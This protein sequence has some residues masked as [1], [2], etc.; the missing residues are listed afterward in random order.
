MTDEFQI[1]AEWTASESACAEEKTTA[2]SLCIQFRDCIATFV[3]DYRSK[4]NR[5]YI[6]TS[7]YPLALWFASSWW[8]LRWEPDTGRPATFSWKMAHEMAA[9]GRGYIWP[10]LTFTSDGEHIDVHCRASHPTEMGPIRYLNTFFVSISAKSFEH[11]VDSFLDLVISRLHA[12]GMPGTD[13]EMLWKIIQGEREDPSLAYSR[14]LEARLGF[15]PDEAPK[16]LLDEI[17][18]REQEA[19][20]EALSEIAAGCVGTNPEA[21]FHAILD[22]TTNPG[23]D[24]A[25]EFLPTGHDSYA[26]IKKRHPRPWELGWALARVIRN[27]IGGT[28]DAVSDSLLS[29][30]L[31]TDKS[32]FSADTSIPR[33][34]PV[35]LALRTENSSASLRFLFSGGVHTTRR[36]EACRFLAD[37]L[38]A[39]EADSWLPVTR[40]KTARQKYQRAFAAEFLCP[41]EKLVSYLN[42]DFSDEAQEDAAIH[43]DVSQ[44]CISAHLAN[45][46]Y[47]PSDSVPIFLTHSV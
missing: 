29:D 28:S 4:S 27:T 1:R 5:D 31:H 6:Y 21:T 18:A 34:I 46:R 45:N 41:I 32:V 22:L 25:I 3:E 39:P 12:E 36:F 14:I 24:G 2:A 11:Q 15:D 42:G 44:A 33:R 10:T 35:G 17:S 20:R 9:A 38:L 37:F 26:E 8:R 40:A 16:K 30:I 19:G 7:M 43:F 47:I 13:L 23:V